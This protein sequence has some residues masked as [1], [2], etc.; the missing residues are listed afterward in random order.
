[1]ILG[2]VTSVQLPQQPAV[3]Y[4]DVSCVCLLGLSEIDQMDS[5]LQALR[6]RYV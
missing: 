4:S 5:K 1:M 3:H 2:F 6:P